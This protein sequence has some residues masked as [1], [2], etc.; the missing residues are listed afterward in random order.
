MRRYEHP[1]V[2]MGTADQRLADDGYAAAST[3]EVTVQPGNRL[4]THAGRRFLKMATWHKSPID[5][6]PTQRHWMKGCSLIL[7]ALGLTVSVGSVYADTASTN[8]VCPGQ[9]EPDKER[10]RCTP[11]LYGVEMRALAAEMAAHPKP[12]VTPIP[13]DERQ[14]YGRAYRRVLKETDIFDA[15]NGKVI[16]HLAA[17]FNFV[18]AGRGKDGWVEIRRGQWVPEAVLGPINTAV[19]KFAGVSLSDNLPVRPFGW[20]L[21]NTQ[22]SRT[23]G[24]KPVRG[25]AELKRYTLINIFAV[26]KV[27]GWEWYLVGPDQWIVQT[28]MAKLT[29]VKR[30]AEVSG[31][32]FAVDL[33]E[34]TLIAYEGDKAVFATLISSGLPQ[35]STTEGLFKI[36][37]RYAVVKMSGAA[38]QPDFYYLPQVPWVM[39]FNKAEQA[40]HGTYWHDGFGFRRSHG[41]VNMS[42]TDAMWAF[43]W[44]QDTPD[45]FVYVYSSGAYT[46]GGPR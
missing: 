38:G 46:R 26:Q 4:T 9:T 27:D 1:C 44:T 20:V 8:G 28:R 36:W 43:Q 10:A 18:N 22:P 37:D 35:W 11:Y 45:A 12:H 7:L 33:Y 17:G 24:A 5:R 14:L 23:P 39:Y 6:A 40:L 34:Q 21:L 2:L 29:S 41:C 19:S 30:P 15:P 42:I 25:T 13:V 3:T 31:K 16:G 32:W